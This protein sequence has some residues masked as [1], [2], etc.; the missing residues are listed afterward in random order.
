M[1]TLGNNHN[2]MILLV[3]ET[4]HHSTHKISSKYVHNFF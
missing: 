4:H 3:S 1:R 2:T